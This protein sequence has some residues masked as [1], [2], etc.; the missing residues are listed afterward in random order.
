[1]ASKSVLLD[2]PNELFPFIFQYLSSI[3]LIKAFSDLQSHRLQALIQPFISQLDVS[4]ESDTWIQT[5][6]PDILNKHNIIAL[7]LQMKYL[8]FISEYLL[9]TN[10]QSVEVINWGPID[11]TGKTVLG[12]LRR[13]LKMFFMTC[14]YSDEDGDL[15]SH[16]F[17]SDSQLQHLAINNCTLYINDIDICTQLTHLS[18]EL[19]GMHPLFILVEHLTGIQELKVKIRSQ[20]CIVQLPPETSEIKPCRS[21]HSVTFTGWIKYFDHMKSFFTNFGS[22][23]ECLS[24][25]IDLMFLTVDGKGLEQGLLDKMPRLSS[26]DLI[27]HSTVADSDPLDIKTFQSF[28]WQ[29]F[30]PIVYWNDRHAHQHT[31][32]TLPYKCDQFH[33]L[34]NEFVSSCVSNRPVSLSFKHVR[35]LS[36]TTTTSLTMETFQFIQKAFPNVKTLELTNWI[37]HPLD[38]SEEDTSVSSVNEDLLFDT[39]LQIPSVTQFCHFTWSQ[40]DNYKTFRRLLSLFPNLICL[41]LDIEQSILRDILTLAHKD[42]LVKTLFA[43][44]EQLKI[45]DFHHEAKPLIDAEFHHFFPRVK[46]L[47][48]EDDDDADIE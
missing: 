46:N 9:S 13:H 3:D 27:I 25:N 6:L 47:I 23:I 32:F 35:S 33:H 8:V 21:L 26:L 24:L 18:I 40:Y 20:D 44:I 37:K 29:K 28:T 48:T 30:N 34:S 11:D 41:E 19:E 45:S 4:Q 31:I 43:N 14:P 15:A 2:L 39:T 38:E 12:Q 16:L 42:D 17:Q 5:Y 7:R 1:M 36:L 22:T 10:I